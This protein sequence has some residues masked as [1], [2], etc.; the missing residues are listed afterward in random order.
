ML[1]RGVVTV[2]LEITNKQLRT[3]LL[4]EIRGFR[5]G[6]DRDLVQEIMSKFEN[7]LRRKEKAL[8]DGLVAKRKIGI[9]LSMGPGG[10]PYMYVMLDEITPEF[11]QYVISQNEGRTFYD[12]EPQCGTEAGRLF[13]DVWKEAVAEGLRRRLFFRHQHHYYTSEASSLQRKIDS[14]TRRN[15][16]NSA[17]KAAS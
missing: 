15:R 13:L 2:K 16:T 1:L 4:K 12:L 8:L 11:V 6:S 17:P 9:G 5:Y 3:R 14:E 7:Q 10:G